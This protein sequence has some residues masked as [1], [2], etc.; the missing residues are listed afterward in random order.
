MLIA[1]FVLIVTF[2]SFWWRGSRSRARSSASALAVALIFVATAFASISST[3]P[4]LALMLGLAVGIDYALFIVARH[5]DQVRAG[6][7]PEESAARATGTAGSAVVFAGVTVLIALIGLVVRQHPVPHDDGH[8]GI[9]RRRDRRA[10]RPHAHPRVPRLRQGRV[11]GCAAAAATRAV[12]GAQR[13]SAAGRRPT[14][15]RPSRRR[16]TPEAR[17]S[18]TRW[19]SGVTRHPIITTIAVVLGLGILAIPAA[20]LRLALPERRHAARRRARRARLR[21][22]RRALRSRLQ[23][24]ARS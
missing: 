18:R 11:V 7:A 10:R 14:A 13:G 1:L 15:A 24:P 22:D 23:R 5:Q 3:T 9:R 16:A 12:R 4:L 6:V 21:P 19:V 8:R 20:S 2:R 17:A